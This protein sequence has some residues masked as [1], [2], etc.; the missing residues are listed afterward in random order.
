MSS[1]ATSSNEAGTVS[2]TSCSASTASGR[3]SSQAARTWPSSRAAASTGDSR[4]TSVASSGRPQGRMAAVRSTAAW[5]SQLFDEATSRPG[6]S[7]PR[8]RASSPVT[9]GASPHRSTG[10]SPATGA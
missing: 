3:A 7:L 5:Q 1:R 4:G 9:H 6:T 10:A 2:T 8:R